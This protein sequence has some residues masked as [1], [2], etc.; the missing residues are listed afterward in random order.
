[1]SDVTQAVAD[2]IALSDATSIG[3]GVVRS[4]TDTL[5]LSDTTKF[6]AGLPFNAP[7]DQLQLVDAIAVHLDINI[8]ES[9]LVQ[10]SVPQVIGALGDTVVVNVTLTVTGTAQPAYVQWRLA[11]SPLNLTLV[12]A[13][14][15]AAG[16]A[17]S[18]ILAQ[19][20]TPGAETFLIYGLNENIISTGVIAILTFTIPLTALL[21]PTLLN[22]LDLAVA[23][24]NNQTINGITDDT[25]L[26]GD[27][28]GLSDS[29]KVCLD[30]RLSLNDTFNF[31]DSVAISG[32]STDIRIS[33]SD[34]LNF[35]DAITALTLH[36]A[37]IGNIQINT[38]DT[39]SLNDSILTA[40]LN[41]TV[42]DMQR[43]VTDAINLSD[44]LDRISLSTN[45]ILDIQIVGNDT[46]VLSDTIQFTQSQLTGP[47]LI[48][49]LRRYL[50]DVV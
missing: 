3:W 45:G 18:K 22:I 16:T 30:L 47:E 40:K 19:G 6:V 12:S 34:S 27:A 17:A 38:A 44:V 1:M 9:G 46:L 26:F 11:Y 39:I 23:T 50:N 28:I 14:I 32:P 43:V 42:L 29:Q 13:A 36:G 49:Y 2:A 4:A 41:A 35:S 37:G 20:G 21:N 33:K 25:V 5:S 15:G 24:A 31:T 10:I 8:L 48:K 7:S